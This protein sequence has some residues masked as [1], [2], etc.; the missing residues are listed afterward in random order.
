MYLVRVTFQIMGWE[1][2]YLNHCFF[3][4]AS[5]SGDEL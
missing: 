4:L 5:I 2:D 3:S 1:A